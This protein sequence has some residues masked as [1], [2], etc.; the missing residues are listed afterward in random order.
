VKAA[1]G[2]IGFVERPLRDD[3][4]GLTARTGYTSKKERLVPVVLT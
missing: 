2:E 3:L 1:P 4:S